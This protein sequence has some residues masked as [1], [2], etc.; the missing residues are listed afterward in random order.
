[1]DSY[2]LNGHLD[3]VAAPPLAADLLETRGKPMR[4]DGSAVT[5]AGT[6]LIQ[7]LVSAKK[8]WQE[9]GHDFTVSPV[10]SALANAA[11][12]LGVDLS[13]IGATET[14]IQM[15]EVDA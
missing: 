7:V 13:A 12:G 2:S 4:V 1:M 9:D 15:T 14:D 3:S 8:Q 5:F 6:L 11:K 10:S